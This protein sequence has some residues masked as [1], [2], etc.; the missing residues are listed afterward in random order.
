MQAV[1][2][3]HGGAKT[4]HPDLDSD[5]DG[6]VLH[7]NPASDT[8]GV[9]MVVLDATG[10]SGV[11]IVFEEEEDSSV[12][13]TAAAFD[14]A[15]QLPIAWEDQS[16]DGQLPNADA[17]AV[18]NGGPHGGWWKSSSGGWAGVLSVFVLVVIML[19]AAIIAL[20]GPA[21]DFMTGFEGDTGEM[22]LQYTPA[23]Q[24][25][26][27]CVCVLLVI[28]AIWTLRR[29]TC[30]WRSTQLD[31]ATTDESYRRSKWTIIRAGMA[32]KLVFRSS[33]PVW[34]HYTL[35]KVRSGSILYTAV[36]LAYSILYMLAKSRSMFLLA[37]TMP[38][39]PHM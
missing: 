29:D 6:V 11:E 33:S 14:K 38:H 13:I 12:T 16:G 32:L 21:I 4:L 28:F 25:I 1:L 3:R 9:A 24:V 15:G 35:A 22:Y 31:H 26:V 7:P 23:A 37:Y 10:S 20:S 36:P 2:A 30:A 39:I 17:D 18:T 27:G 5:T 8:D 34:G 19:Y